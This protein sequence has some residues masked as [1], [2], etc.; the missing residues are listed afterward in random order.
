[1]RCLLGKLPTRDQPS[2]TSLD[3]GGGDEEMKWAAMIMLCLLAIGLFAISV[4]LDLEH[5]EGWGWFVFI[6]FVC[7]CGIIGLAIHEE[8]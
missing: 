1:M 2:G 3:V 7:V 5:A 4:R 8:E 6:G